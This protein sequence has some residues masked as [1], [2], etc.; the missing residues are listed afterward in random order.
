MLQDALLDIHLKERETII[1]KFINAHTKEADT[2]IPIELFQ[3]LKGKIKVLAKENCDIKVQYQEL[4]DKYSIAL[5]EYQKYKQICEK[6]EN[7]PFKGLLDI[8]TTL[9]YTKM[10]KLMASAYAIKSE[11]QPMP[12]PRPAPALNIEKNDKPPVGKVLDITKSEEEEE[13]DE[14]EEIVDE[15]DMIDEE[16]IQKRLKEKNPPQLFE[17]DEVSEV[18]EESEEE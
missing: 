2:G 3:K 13:D 14:E 1:A 18:S 5:Q 10:Q 6:F 12:Q 9:D 8:A 15:E 17:D 4:D 11:Q 7:P 16:E